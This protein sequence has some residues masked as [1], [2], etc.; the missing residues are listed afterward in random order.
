MHV[1]YRSFSDRPDAPR[2]L[3]TIAIAQGILEL[4]WVPSFSLPGV[5]TTYTILVADLPIQT[6]SQTIGLI[7]EPHYAYTFSSLLGAMPLSCHQYQFTV[8]AENDAG[9]SDPSQPVVSSFP[10]GTNVINCQA[11]I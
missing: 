10:A 11:M 2:A 3:N 4:V 1:L 6:M 8:F 9:K 7:L 5:N